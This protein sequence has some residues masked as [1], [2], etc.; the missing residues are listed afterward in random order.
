MPE[1]LRKLVDPVL[2]QGLELH[3]R[4]QRGERPSL[5]AEQ[6]A[7]KRL[8]GFADQP[9]PWGTDTRTGFLGLRYA[10]TCWL[11]ELFIQHSPAFWADQWN[12]DKLEMAL[13]DSQ[14]RYSEFWEQV[15]LAEK[16]PDGGAALETFWLCVVLGFR[17]A[18][19]Q[20]PD[21][22]REWANAMRTRAAANL[23]PEPPSPPE[24]APTANA[25]LLLGVAAYRN[26]VW[27]LTF[28]I[29][30]S[31]PLVLLMLTLLNYAGEK[32]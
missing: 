17:G 7:L 2:Q 28:G 29:L 26:M 10:L 3:T 13:F 5:A 27:W 20:Q 1:E 31:V 12:E 15:R 9:T 8:L 4:L 32:P 25:P 18:R 11:D 23:P 16:V 30:L 19:G 6:L 21:T 22:L 14:L 24:Q